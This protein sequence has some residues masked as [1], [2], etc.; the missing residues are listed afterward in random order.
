MVFKTFNLYMVILYVYLVRQGDFTL[1][2][3]SLK[4][5]AR[6][7]FSTILYIA[8]EKWKLIVRIDRIIEVFE[9]RR[10]SNYRIVEN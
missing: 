4:I 10:F 1:S 9:L 5:R 7:D 6:V 8:L 3:Y 2:V